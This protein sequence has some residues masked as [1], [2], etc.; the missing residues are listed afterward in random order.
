MHPDPALPMIA[1][2]LTGRSLS[3]RGLLRGGLGLAGGLA[4]GGVLAA[5]GGSSTSD[6]ASPTS[7]T[8]SGT[9]NFLNYPDW[10]GKTEAADF[11][12]ANS[13]VK[14][15]QTATSDGGEA[16]IA[17]QIAKNRGAFDLV[18][19]G[20]VVSARLKAGKLLAD[21][22]AG[23]VP[24]LANISASARADFPWG[25]PTDQGK[26]GL[27]V[28]TDLVKTPPTSWKELF[29]MVGDYSGKVVFPDY[30]SDVLGIALLA[31]GYD[32]N[33]A[34]QS[35]LDAA[36]DLIIKAKPHLKAF[37]SGDQ[38]DGLADGSVVMSVFYDYSYAAVAP[39]NKNIAWVQPSEG[40]PAYIEGWV[41]LAGS[42]RKAEVEAFMN[43]HLEPKV[44]GGFI[45][46]T[47]ASYL[48]PAAEPYIDPSIKSD[49]ALK[50]DPS[51]KLALEQFVSAEGV[52][53]RNKVW[54][55]VKAA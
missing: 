10:I 53:V 25:I 20:C 13:G 33:S 28:R 46:A 32:V 4:V 2:R 47:Q 54:E 55:Q 41:P 22:D 50:Y 36:R 48:M 24:N 51:T 52:S 27:G 17:A 37:L 1:P 42:A 35:E 3:R 7:T 43:Y 21:F 15:K 14:I 34:K 18:L 39:K 31:L 11:E 44:Y 16:A 40:L 9:I 5:C 6:S 29:D 49:V 8:L 12:A 45:N 38:S 30:D 26:V 23:S 19:A